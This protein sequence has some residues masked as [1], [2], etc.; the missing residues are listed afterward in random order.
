MLRMDAIL[1]D[2]S[3]GD[4]DY[5]V[6]VESD[7]PPE[8]GPWDNTGYVL[9]V[10]KHVIEAFAEHDLTWCGSLTVSVDDKQL[11]SFVD[12]QESDKD[13]ARQALNVL[14]AWDQGK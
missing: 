11:A 2:S 6:H 12:D 9:D 10:F 4:N 8:A 3:M 14:L 1:Y 7:V 13:A 5:T